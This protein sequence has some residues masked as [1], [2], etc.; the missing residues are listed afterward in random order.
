MDNIKMI[1]SL[2]KLIKTYESSAEIKKNEDQALDAV[3][4]YG[5]AEGLKLALAEVRFFI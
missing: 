2:M 4:D 1:Q 3:Y 5:I